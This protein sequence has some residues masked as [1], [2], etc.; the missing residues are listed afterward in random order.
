MKIA[1]ARATPRQPVRPGAP[2]SQ[3]RSG[4]RFEPT[5]AGPNLLPS[6][7]AWLRSPS[8]ASIA[9]DPHLKG[10][11]L[12][13]AI[14]RTYVGL[15]QDFQKIFDPQFAGSSS[16]A[17]SWYAMAIYASRGAGAGMAAAQRALELVG[18]D[19]DSRA[20]L[21]NAFPQ[22]PQE[23]WSTLPGLQE[24]RCGHLSRATAYLTA[25]ALASQ[26]RPERLHLEPRALTLSALRL[27]SLL[28]QGVD[29]AT[30]TRTILNMLEDGNR[31]IFSDIGVSGQRF[32]ELRRDRPEL[33]PEEVLVHF[34]DRPELAA[35]AYQDGLTWA[36]GPGPLPTNFDRHY[37]FD[38]KHLLATALALY[39]RASQLPNQPMKDRLIA[40]AGNLMAYHEQSQ[41]AVPAFLP[42][43]VL[44]GEADRAAVM[45]ILTPQIEVVHRGGTWKYGQFE[46]PD[47]DGSV[48]TPPCTERNWAVF[49]HRWPPILDYFGLCYQ[50]PE[51]LWPMPSP[52]P[53]LGLDG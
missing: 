20:R 45:E 42:G 49:E 46:Q 22:V 21:C 34:S 51:Q 2:G 39:Q 41:V 4:D 15:A 27:A 48:W 30:V 29:L 35:R 11:E 16:L 5:P 8:A 28:A 6:R 10:L 26:T 24:D 53:L 12:N 36:A 43:Q 50:H 33:A 3:P 52:D 23:M 37:R 38:S 47:L 40:H 19:G 32:L 13:R 14:N 1:T 25:M 31:R 18:D 17:P 9:N 7:P 44:P